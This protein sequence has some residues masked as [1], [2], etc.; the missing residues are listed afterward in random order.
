MDN[1]PKNQFSFESRADFEQLLCEI[2][3]EHRVILEIQERPDGPQGYSGSQVCYFTVENKDPHGATHQDD[4]VTKSATLLERRVLQL[5]SSQ[6]CAVPPVVIPDVTG[7]GRSL[8]YMPFLEARPPLDLGHP[9]S[10][11]TYAIADGLAKIH[12]VNRNQPPSWLPRASDDLEGRLWFHGWREQWEANLGVPEFAAEFGAYTTRLE[13][14]LERFRRTL[15]ELTSEGTSLTLINV[16][17]IPD[18]IRLW[19]GMACF[20]DWEQAC[21]GSFYL[22]LPNPFNVETVLVYRDALA[23]HGHPIPVLEF[24]ERFHEI[25]RYMGLR[26]LGY[27]LWQWAQG[28]EERRRGRWFLY[29]TLGLATHGR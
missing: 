18:H 2:H 27:A 1:I 4:L 8:I 11:L 21:Y 3:G 15:Q 5:L 22:D 29:Y 10:P 14:A 25:G 20:I 9:Q 6:G 17:P 23:R 28:G 24:Q 19:R 7:D 12:A 16:D 13:A 26:Y